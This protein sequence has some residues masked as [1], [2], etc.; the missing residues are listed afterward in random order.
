MSIAD[1]VWGRLA[2]FNP[3][4][5]TTAERGHFPLLRAVRGLLLHFV[6]L[7]RWAVLLALLWL[8]GLAAVYEMHTSRLEAWLF[9]RINPRMAVSPQSGANDS[10]RFPKSGPYD[11]R[12]SYNRLPQIIPALAFHHFALARQPRA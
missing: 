8:I 7:L 2:R 12:L 6:G 3:P 1:T 10:I 5:G 9:T 11:K 4:R